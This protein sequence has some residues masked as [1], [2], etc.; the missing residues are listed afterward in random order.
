MIALLRQ[1]AYEKNGVKFINP[2]AFVEAEKAAGSR[3][4]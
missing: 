4:R 2:V 1:T 3:A